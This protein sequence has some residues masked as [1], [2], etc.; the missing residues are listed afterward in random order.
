MDVTLKNNFQKFYQ[1]LI[2]FRI[3]QLAQRL[4]TLLPWW[5]LVLTSTH[6]MPGLASN[7]IT[8]MSA[9]TKI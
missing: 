2:S 5:W 9:H 8:Q 3:S 6:D 4:K 7:A 1:L